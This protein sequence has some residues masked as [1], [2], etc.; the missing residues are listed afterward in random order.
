M[1][2]AA[3][4]TMTVNLWQKFV[5]FLLRRRVRITAFIFIA[6]VAEDLLTRVQPH[7]LLHVHDYK[8]AIGLALVFTGVALRSWA[9]GTLQKRKQLATSG[10]YQL[11][12]HPLYVGSYL[13]MVGFCI[14][15]DDAENIWVVLGPILFLYILRAISEERFLASIFPEQWPAFA[16]AVPRFIPRRI[17]QAAFADW[18][19]SQWLANREY[20][21]LGAAF[22]GL[23][24]IQLWHVVM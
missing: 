3:Q 4:A 10:P 24:A 1:A 6:L 17:P 19:F 2:N 14:L 15:V 9:A 11:V 13:M 18:S 16:K 22:L 8:V 20:Q 21:A 5:D 23:A 7:N 12:R